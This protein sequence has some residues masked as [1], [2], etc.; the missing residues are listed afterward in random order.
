[1]KVLAVK[2]FATSFNTYKTSRLGF[3]LLPGIFFLPK[4][5]EDAEEERRLNLLYTSTL[6]VSCYVLFCNHGAW[7]WAEGHQ[8]AGDG[9]GTE[10]GLA[11]HRSQDPEAEG[12]WAAI[13]HWK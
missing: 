12:E 10:K 4:E 2:Q 3:Q 1:M 9:R 13:S 6:P 11:E 5:Q 8:W 7:P